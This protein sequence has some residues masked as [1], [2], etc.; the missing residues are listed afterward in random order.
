MTREY[1]KR[2]VAL[3]A[4]LIVAAGAVCLAVPPDVPVA[5]DAD[6]AAVPDVARPDTAS[7]RP[8]TPLPPP[9]EPEP[10][11]RGYLRES[12]RY[13]NIGYGP[14]H[15]S[16]QSPFQALRL[17]ITP[18]PPTTIRS[19]QFELRAG[20]TWANVWNQDYNFL[21]DYE[22]LQTTLSLAYGVTEKLELEL[23]LENRSR[24]GGELD[25]LSRWFHDVVGIGQNGRDLVPR[26]AFNFELSPEGQEP[27]RLSQSDKGPFNRSALLTLQHNVTLGRGWLP[28][29][30]YAVTTRFDASGTD[31]LVGVG[32]WDV[33]VSV[34]VARR[35]GEF[36][37]YGT[38]GAARFSTDEFRGLELRTSQLS[39]LGAV[40]WRYVEHQSIVVQYLVTEGQVADFAPFDEPSH[41]ISLGFKWEAVPGSIIELGLIENAVV[42]DNTPD[43]GLVLGYSRRF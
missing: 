21:L 37:A 5:E 12:P 6:P 41:E 32:N 2:L 1:G 16:S 22:M 43:V 40:E 33:G 35:F 8:A 19:G 17:G 26:D 3:M 11:F 30:S 23:E 36:Y 24:F 4:M 38:L 31:D 18:R 9:A 10:A 14:L 28:A 25:S 20:A 42:F 39:L 13:T 15:V 27:I 7:D 34:A 29:V